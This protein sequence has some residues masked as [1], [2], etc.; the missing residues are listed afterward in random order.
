MLGINAGIPRYV[1]IYWTAA[2]FT[3]RSLL[4]V[5]SGLGRNVVLVACWT[6]RVA[7]V[8]GPS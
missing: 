8:N 3:E 4:F 2:Y 1:I 7:W 6:G 5:G